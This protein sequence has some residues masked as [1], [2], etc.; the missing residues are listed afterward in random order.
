VARAFKGLRWLLLRKWEHLT[1][2]EK[3]TIRDL[4][5]ANKRAFGAS[6]L[7]L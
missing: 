4:E 3:G 7:V 1:S 6:A 2:A 5:R